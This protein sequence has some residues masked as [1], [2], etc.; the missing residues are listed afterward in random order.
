MALLMTIK[1]MLS[2]KGSPAAGPDIPRL[3]EERGFSVE[4]SEDGGLTLTPP[5]GQLCCT[6]S[7]TPKD[8]ATMRLRQAEPYRVLF[9]YQNGKYYVNDEKE[10][11]Y[12]RLLERLRRVR[13]APDLL[14]AAGEFLLARY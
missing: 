3:L 5:G 13:R 9:S 14:D 4:E 1:N 7:H 8:G 6:L 12:P 2:G 10:E 11:G